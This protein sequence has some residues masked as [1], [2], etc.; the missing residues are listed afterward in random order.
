[1]PTNIIKVIWRQLHYLQ[2]VMVTQEIPEDWKKANDIPTYKKGKKEK[3]WTC[4]LVILISIPWKERE[5]LILE[6]VSRY[7]KKQVGQRSC[8]VFTKGDIQNPTG[9]CTEQLIPANLVC[10]GWLDYKV[11]RRSPEDPLNLNYSV[12]LWRQ[13]FM[14]HIA[15]TRSKCAEF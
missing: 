7:M 11:S 12:I 3:L 13:W 15:I 2:K 8:G 9:H 4:S 10:A 14:H 6:I 1:M 5:Q